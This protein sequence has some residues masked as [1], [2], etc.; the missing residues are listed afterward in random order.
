MILQP[1]LFCQ[2]KNKAVHSDPYL[3]WNDIEVV[4]HEE[5]QVH[6]QAE[7]LENIKRGRRAPYD[8]HS[9]CP[10]SLPCLQVSSTPNLIAL[11]SQLNMGRQKKDNSH[12]FWGRIRGISAGEERRD[13]GGGKDCPVAEGGGAE[14]FVSMSK[15]YLHSLLSL[16]N[17]VS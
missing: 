11:I 5:K 16:R 14:M 8:S 12:P 3:L 15:I 7:V 2:Q 17:K 9:S 6:K 1:I 10:L 4:R 13:T